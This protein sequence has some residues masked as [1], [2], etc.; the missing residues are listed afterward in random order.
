MIRRI[1]RRL[2][3]TLD[4]K[5]YKKLEDGFY[6]RK[7]E[8]TFGNKQP[9]E[10]WLDDT[11]R[12]ILGSRPGAFIDIGVNVGQTLTKVKS[13]NA[14]TEYYGFEPNP[15]CCFYV[16]ELIKREQYRNCKVIPVGL[17]DKAELLKLWL[18][19]NS[20]ASASLVSDFREK[21]FYMLEKYVPVLEGD[22][23]L[24]NLNIDSISIIKIDVEGGELEVIRGLRNS[25]AK[26][27]PYILCEVLPVRD[28][29]TEIGGFRKIRQESL[30]KIL[31]EE[32]YKIY[33]IM[34]DGRILP[35]ESIGIHS[36][37]SLCDYVFATEQQAEL[38]FT[39]LPKEQAAIL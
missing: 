23:I 3:K 26:Y 1:M 17:S 9:R 16:N 24:N 35:L 19:S 15:T 20:D 28:V 8:R 39:H 14:N 32:N 38:L 33:R 30:E 25:I 31:A 6:N 18:R 21:S 36:D 2:T 5:F 4:N 37:L 34:H 22:Y 29:N 13:I 11:I 12:N 7:L 27:K 10:L